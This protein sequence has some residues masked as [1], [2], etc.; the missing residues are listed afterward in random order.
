[1]GA[2][3]SKVIIIDTDIEHQYTN[4]TGEFCRLLCRLNAI[5]NI[6]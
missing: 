3:T 4:K 5:L 1:M 6:Y 2:P